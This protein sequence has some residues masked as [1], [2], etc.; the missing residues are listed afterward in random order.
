MDI[1]LLGSRKGEKAPD[2]FTHTGG[3]LTNQL[4]CRLRVLFHDRWLGVGGPQQGLS[5]A[6]AA[7]CRRRRALV[8]ALAARWRARL[9]VQ[10]ADAEPAG[11]RR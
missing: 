10:S 1:R 11:G 6:L 7:G 8:G 9:V 5:Q 4:N 2:Q 3:V